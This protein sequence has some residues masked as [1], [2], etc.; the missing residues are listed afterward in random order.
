MVP[1]IRRRGHCVL[2]GGRD[3]LEIGYERRIG[4]RIAGGIPIP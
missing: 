1:F 3:R 2:H 4:R